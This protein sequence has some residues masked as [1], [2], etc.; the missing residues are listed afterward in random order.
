MKKVILF[1]ILVVLAFSGCKKKDTQTK[2]TTGTTPAAPR[3]IF[4]FKFDSTQV[5]LNAIGQP[6][7][8]PAGHQA[9]SPRFNLM[10][11]HY[12]EMAA[13]DTTGVGRGVVLFVAPTVTTGIT[14]GTFTNAIDHDKCTAVA[15]GQEFY[16]VPLSSVT[17]GTYKWL[18]VSL[19]YQ[20]YDITYKFTYGGNP[21]YFTGT[22]ASFVGF[23]TWINSYKIKTQNITVNANKLQGYWGF[24]TTT[25]IM[26]V[27]TTTTTTG[28]APAGAT[29]VVNPLFATSP[30]PAGSCLATGQFV[31]AGGTNQ[32]LTITGNETKDIIINVSLST[33]K[34]FEWV[35][36]SGDTYYEPTAGD[37][38]VDMGIRGLIPYI[39]P[40]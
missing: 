39:L 38:V 37:T 5:R 22:V 12:I 26:G 40:Q 18:R 24:E 34:S 4:K 21:Y 32:L 28:Q 27:S 3:L 29:T 1:S 35:E 33:N 16:S 10:S 23:N 17:P 30:I 13:T 6:V 20:N 14:T 7:G 15:D 2:T 8:I 11:G 25:T 36:H 9:Q 19:A 31:N